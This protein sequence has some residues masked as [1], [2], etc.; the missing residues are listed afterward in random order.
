MNRQ[1]KI[2]RQ[3]LLQ[4]LF[5]ELQKNRSFRDNLCVHWPS[6]RQQDIVVA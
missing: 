4:I 2:L 1:R 6:L 5:A 3:Y